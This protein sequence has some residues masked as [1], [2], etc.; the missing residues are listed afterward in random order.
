MSDFTINE[1][2]V[3]QKNLQ[4]HYKSIWEPIGPET[5]QNK[6]LWMLG[7]VGEV[8]DIVKKNGGKKES[9]RIAKPLIIFGAG[10]GILI[11]GLVVA[12]GV[13]EAPFRKWIKEYRGNRL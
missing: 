8:I 1:M 11:V 6:L 10:L 12:L 7:E 5:G 9:E 2:L 4:D 3:M 13:L